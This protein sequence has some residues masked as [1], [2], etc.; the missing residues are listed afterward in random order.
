MV[1]N[2]WI[3]LGDNRDF[4]IPSRIVDSGRMWGD[5]ADPEETEGKQKR[6][7]EE[8]EEIKRKKVK[9][10]DIAERSKTGKK[11]G[12][13]GTMVRGRGKGAKDA[14]GPSRAKDNNDMS[15][16]DEDK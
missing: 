15:M 2:E 10:E 16:T 13:H 4:D 6:V 11:N 9:L 14:A 3:A 7:K 8:K 5:T 12:K 1:P